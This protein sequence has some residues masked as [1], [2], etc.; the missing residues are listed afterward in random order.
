[1]KRI[2]V[3]VVACVGVFLRVSR[4]PFDSYGIPLFDYA[5][6]LGNLASSVGISVEV[7]E[8]V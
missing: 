5:R 3:E 4:A 8:E 6:S 7:V 2:S 1:V